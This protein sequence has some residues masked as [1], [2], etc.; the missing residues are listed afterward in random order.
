MTKKPR[1]ISDEPTLLNLLDDFLPKKGL[2]IAIPFAKD[3]M[4]NVRDRQNLVES[5]GFIVR[6][7]AIDAILKKIIGA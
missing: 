3:L 5:L 4:R 6:I 1:L 7:N 2:R